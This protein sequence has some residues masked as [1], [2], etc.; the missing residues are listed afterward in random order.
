MKYADT[1]IEMLV[2]HE[3][4]SLMP[5]RCPAGKI[6]IG[7]GRNIEDNGISR[8]EAFYLL[9]NDLIRIGDECRRHLTYF[10][11]MNP[12]RQVVVMNMVF[13]MGMRRLKNF[14]KMHSCLEIHDYRGAARE[15]KDSKWAEQV[16]GRAT[17]LAAIME[18]GELHGAAS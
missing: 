4:L 16:K 1:L 13:N 10:A 14:K 6:T 9:K 5:Y 17:E 18:S 12:A 3:G 15:M 2:R 11:Q 8:A 7:I